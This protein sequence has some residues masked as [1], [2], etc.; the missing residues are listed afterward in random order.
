M[1]VEVPVAQVLA[2][3]A[4]AVHKLIVALNWSLQA[5]QE[6]TALA[7][8]LGQLACRVAEHMRLR[9]L[10]AVCPATHARMRQWNALW[11][12]EIREGGVWQSGRAGCTSSICCCGGM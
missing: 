5:P 3:H 12:L 4:A 9:E 8:V 2:L 6:L 7:L 10:P 11:P 1:V